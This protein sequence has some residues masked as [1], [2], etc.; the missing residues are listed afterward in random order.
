MAPSSQESY[1]RELLKLPVPEAKEKLW[2]DGWLVGVQQMDGDP[3]YP[4]YQDREGNPFHGKSKAGKLL[5]AIEIEG[6]HIS[7]I[8]FYDTNTATGDAV[9]IPPGRIFVQ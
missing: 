7:K 4:V 3:T 6:D 5:A 1:V 9:P 2:S 8:Q